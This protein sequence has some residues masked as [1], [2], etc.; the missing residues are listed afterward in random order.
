VA[1]KRADMA[2]I[3][4]LFIKTFTLQR[5][6]TDLSDEEFFWE[7]LPGGWTSP[8]IAEYPGFISARP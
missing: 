2:L 8:H 6:C 7:P 5:A 1:G 3:T 4:M